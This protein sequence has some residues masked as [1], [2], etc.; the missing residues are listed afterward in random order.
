MQETDQVLQTAKIKQFV[1]SQPRL[2]RRHQWPIHNTTRMAASE[3][4][5]GNSRTL[6]SCSN[7]GIIK[8]T[9]HGANGYAWREWRT[10]GGQ[11]YVGDLT[12]PCVGVVEHTEA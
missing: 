9:V 4:P 3:F 12:P 2:S 7:C 1:K 11:V 5:D 10:K 6:R 8:V